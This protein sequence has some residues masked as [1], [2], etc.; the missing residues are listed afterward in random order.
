MLC[1][2]T[3]DLTF[4]V[5]CIPGA[6]SLTKD[7][8]FLATCK[9]SKV[10]GNFIKVYKKNMLCKHVSFLYLLISLFFVPFQMQGVIT[11]MMSCF[12]GQEEMILLKVWTQFDWRSTQ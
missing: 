1:S 7:W 5:Q 2:Y 12:T 8:I 3:E 11:L 9:P 4:I 10:D 6:K